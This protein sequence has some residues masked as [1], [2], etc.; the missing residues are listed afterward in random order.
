[1]DFWRTKVGVCPDFTTYTILYSLRSEKGCYDNGH[2][3]LRLPSQNQSYKVTV[4]VEVSPGQSAML[5]KIKPNDSATP[6][7]MLCQVHDELQQGVNPNN[8]WIQISPIATQTLT[9]LALSAAASS[10]GT[11][12]PTKRR[13]ISMKLLTTLAPARFW[14]FKCRTRWRRLLRSFLASAW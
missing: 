3:L 11:R 8:Q 13:F 6:R 4:V 1:M 9:D 7:L 12:P 5:G 10:S 14:F 2:A